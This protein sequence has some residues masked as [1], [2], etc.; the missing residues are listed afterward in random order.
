[1]S[2]DNHQK[3]EEVTG[4]TGLHSGDE[5]KWLRIFENGAMFKERGATREKGGG[6]LLANHDRT[7]M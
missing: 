4:I 3:K 2:R 7:A 5:I 6:V 1:M